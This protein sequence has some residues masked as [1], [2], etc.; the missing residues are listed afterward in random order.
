[1]HA[2][3]LY[4]NC[5]HWYKRKVSWKGHLIVVQGTGVILDN[6]KARR[7]CLSKDDAAF[8]MTFRDS[9]FFNYQVH[10]N[11]TTLF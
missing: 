7:W 10:A 9:F 3:Y 2:V 5:L 6:L 1:M 4:A 8:A 11:L